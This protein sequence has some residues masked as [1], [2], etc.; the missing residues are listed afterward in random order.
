MRHP[1]SD[2]ASLFFVELFQDQNTAEKGT[3]AGQ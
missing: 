3:F 1:T 2:A